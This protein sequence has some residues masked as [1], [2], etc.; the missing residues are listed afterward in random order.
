M[1]V[2][3]GYFYRWSHRFGVPTVV[4]HRR[5][6]GDMRARVFPSVTALHDFLKHFNMPGDGASRASA[7][8]A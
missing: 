4:F 2:C 6:V 1:G 7:A 5:N 8:S 3:A